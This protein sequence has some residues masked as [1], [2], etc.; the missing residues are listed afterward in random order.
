[1][2]SRGELL[3][4]PA[5]NNSFN[6]GGPSTTVLDD[7]GNFNNY[8][9]SNPVRSTNKFLELEDL[10]SE[11]QTDPNNWQLELTDPVETEDEETTV[12]NWLLRDPPPE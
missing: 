10:P 5:G 3:G 1:M 12:P 9:L 7:V 4:N 8:S 6:N 11:G 2:P